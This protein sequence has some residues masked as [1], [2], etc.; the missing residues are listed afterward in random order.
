[1]INVGAA[2]ASAITIFI[3]IG[4]ASS[5]ALAGSTRLDRAC[6]P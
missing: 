4:G 5:W 3:G 6:L 1:L 2:I